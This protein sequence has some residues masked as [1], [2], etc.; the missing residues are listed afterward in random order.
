MDLVSLKTSLGEA[1]DEL[2]RIEEDFE[3]LKSKRD[4]LLALVESISRFLDEAGD[5]PV[6][7]RPQGQVSL[8]DERPK[9]MIVRDVFPKDGTTLTV[10]EIHKRVNAKGEVIKNPDAIRVILR[11]KTDY[12]EAKG[13]ARY[14]LRYP[15]SETQKATEVAS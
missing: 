9:W 4:S 6:L 2:R 12:F 14:G 8:F 15:I 10:P 5:R 11:R 1:Q 13:G 3:K 7:V